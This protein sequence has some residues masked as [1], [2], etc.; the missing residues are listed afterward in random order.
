[1]IASQSIHPNNIQD[2]ALNLTLRGEVSVFGYALIL[3][4]RRC[5]YKVSCILL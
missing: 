2:F 1:M 3:S 5:V 4:S